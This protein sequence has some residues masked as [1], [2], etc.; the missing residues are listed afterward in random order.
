MNEEPKESELILWKLAE[1]LDSF[2]F[3]LL[4]AKLEIDIN[5]LKLVNSQINFKTI[6]LEV[7]SRES[8]GHKRRQGGLYKLSIE[9]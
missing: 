8:T 5:L 7:L 6:I 4:W 1:K 2:L 3:Q 9:G